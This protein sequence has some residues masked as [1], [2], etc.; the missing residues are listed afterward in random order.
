MCLSAYAAVYTSTLRISAGDYQASKAD[1]REL[2]LNNVHTF[3]YSITN[4]D[5]K[6]CIG[7]VNLRL[8]ILFAAS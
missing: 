8:P 5:M 2:F 6:Q 4:S 7:C 1:A 3:N